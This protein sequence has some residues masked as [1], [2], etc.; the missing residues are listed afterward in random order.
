MHSEKITVWDVLCV[1][2]I[3]GRNLVVVG[4]FYRAVIKKTVFAQYEEHELSVFWIIGHLC[5]YVK[6]RAYWYN[7]AIFDAILSYLSVR[8]QPICWKGYFK[9]DRTIITSRI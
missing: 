2:V 5:S 6:A 3:T 1:S 4:Q 7:T 8:Y 9:I